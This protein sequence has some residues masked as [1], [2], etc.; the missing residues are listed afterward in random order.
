MATIQDQL[1]RLRKELAQV[2]EELIEAEAELA[3]RQA[4]INAF[5][6]VL[7]ATLGPLTDQLA[8]LEADIRNYMDRIERMRS[9]SVFGTGHVAV[10]K[11]YQ[12]VWDA[13]HKSAVKPPPEPPSAS[14]EAQIKTLYR[15]LARRF[16][17]D[18]AADEADRTHR[19]EL[20]A[21]VNSAYAARSLAELVALDQKEGGTPIRRSRGQTS[22]E[23]R[24]LH[25]RPSVQ[26]QLEAKMAHRT[27]EDLIKEM[28]QD[29]KRKI[30]RRE[31][32]RDFLRSQFNELDLPP[33]INPRSRSE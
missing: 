30:A 1:A 33:P 2:Q 28:A 25:L 20:M 13:P 23:I 27:G 16:H 18:L 32:E 11:Q 31:V 22:R 17:P 21:A 12:R 29:L 19:T 14:V 9:E 26:M 24:T 6:A 8:A 5:E 7:E 4:E 3:D 15:R 10:E